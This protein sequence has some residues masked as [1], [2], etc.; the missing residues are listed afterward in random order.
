MKRS[1]MLAG[2]WK[3]NH[4]PTVAADIASAMRE[5]AVDTGTVRLAIFPTALSMSAVLDRLHGSA[6]DVGVQEVESS[7]EGAYTGTNSATHARDMGCTYA[8]VGHSE[9]RQLYGDS[10]EDVGRRT[11]AALD[12]GLLVVL[13]VGETLAQRESGDAESVVGEQLN[14]AL[15]TLPVDRWSAITVAYEP[16]WAIGT[17]VT[18]TPDQAQ[19]MH[20]FIRQWLQER[21]P[22]LAASTRLLYGGSV[23][24]ANAHDLLSCPDIDGALVGGASLQADSFLELLSIA[25][26]VQ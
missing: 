2:N 24:P 16:V 1:I 12:A 3:L 8:L 21:S 7:H 19:A 17:G 13:C 22:A 10:N 26:L 18:A 9:R 20:A 25:K 4:T 14:A 6:I 11:V 15:G 5:G 23:K